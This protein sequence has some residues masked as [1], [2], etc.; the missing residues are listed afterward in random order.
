MKHAQ[1]HTARD[2]RDLQAPAHIRE[3]LRSLLDKHFHKSQTEMARRLG[4]TQGAVSRWMPKSDEPRAGRS[5]KGRPKRRAPLKRSLPDLETFLHLC[6]VTKTS[7]T[8]LLFGDGAETQEGSRPH[9]DLLRDVVQ[10]VQRRVEIAGAADSQVIAEFFSKVD[11]EK[12]LELLCRE[13]QRDAVE[14]S[15]WVAEF[16]MLGQAMQSAQALGSSALEAQLEEIL[17]HCLANP[18]KTTFYR[19][20]PV[21]LARNYEPMSRLTR[22]LAAPPRGRRKTAGRSSGA[23]SVGAGTKPRSSP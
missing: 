12:M 17:A 8:W 5:A 20:R 3:R 16:A 14:M 15:N 18:P 7:P 10:E 6:T 2:V 22:E 9:G 19:L 13:S 4:I 21:P 11:G 1:T 23:A